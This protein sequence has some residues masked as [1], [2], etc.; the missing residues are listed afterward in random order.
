M[1]PLMPGSNESAGSACLLTDPFAPRR[2]TACAL[3]KR[4]AP[5]TVVNLGLVAAAVGAQHDLA[6]KTLPA[7][8]PPMSTALAPLPPMQQQTAVAAAQSAEMREQTVAPGMELDVLKAIL[9]R[10]S[11]LRRLEHLAGQRD[12]A[13][14]VPQGL[15]DLLDL[16]RIATVEAV[17][18]VVAWREAQAAPIPFVWNGINYLL[19]VPSDLD[20][21]DRLRPLNMWLGFGVARNPFVVP[22]PMESGAGLH[23]TS[24]DRKSVV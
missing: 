11:Y 22:L 15:P 3:R 14:K 17:E 6:S 19:K 4:R 1:S 5:T 2:E 21:L 8:A 13:T 9:V 23:A 10:E 20:F 7:H 16:C 18:A 12:A 24:A